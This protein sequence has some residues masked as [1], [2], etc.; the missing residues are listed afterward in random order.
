MKTTIATTR[1]KLFN[2][3]LITLGF[4]SAF[5]PF[6]T[7]LYLPALPSLSKEFSTSPSVAQLSLTMSMLGLAIGQILIGPIS[8]K[9]G[10]KKLLL[11]SLFIFIIA[12]IGCILSTTIHTFNLMRLF[13]GMAGAGGI[14]LSRSIATDLYSGERLTQFISMMSAVNG[15]APVAAPIIG[16]I[17]LSFAHW[18]IIFWVLL[19]V[20]LALIGLSINLSESLSNRNRLQTPLINSFVNY[21]NLVFNR[22]YIIHFLIYMFSSFVLFTYI[23]SSTFILQEVYKMSSLLFSLCFAINAIV[24]GVGC[25]VA[26]HLA[27]KKSLRYGMIIMFVGAIFSVISLNLLHSALIVEVTFMI[28]LLGFGLLQPVPMSIALDSERNNAGVASAA[29]GASGF[30]AGGIAAPLVGSG[31]M[32]ITTSIMFVVGAIIV[33]FCVFL[34]LRMKKK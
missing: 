14:V 34:S 19:F 28:I 30:L 15:I 18:K 22:T 8:D 16:G 21:K 32:L 31:N 23:S 4:L 13:Q 7:D 10:R 1:R 12:T 27:G 25:A 29:L 9:Y 6:V 2:Y 33:S 26:G 3:L 5:G 24:I 20:G 11:G 17:I